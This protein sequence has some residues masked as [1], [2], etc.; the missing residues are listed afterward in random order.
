MQYTFLIIGRSAIRRERL[1]KSFGSDQLNTGATDFTDFGLTLSQTM[2]YTSYILALQLCVIL[3]SS[4]SYCQATL[5]KETD[6]LKEYFVSMI[7]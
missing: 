7:F 6:N 1:A 5:L 2:N 4:S 3:G